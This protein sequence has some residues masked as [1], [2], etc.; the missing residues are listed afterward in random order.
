MTVLGLLVA[1]FITQ[2]Q[3]FLPTFSAQASFQSKTVQQDSISNQHLSALVVRIDSKSNLSSSNNKYQKILII[4]SNKIFRNGSY[5]SINKRRYPRKITYSPSLTNCSTNVPPVLKT[6]FGLIPKKEWDMPQTP[7]Y[8]AEQRLLAQYYRGRQLPVL[9]YGNTGNA[10]RVLQTLL[11]YNR[12]RVR[13]TGDFDVITEAAV[14]AFQSN[15]RLAADG[16]VGSRT[17][18]E[19]TR[20]A[21]IY[22]KRDP[23]EIPMFGNEPLLPWQR[24]FRGNLAE[25]TLSI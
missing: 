24:S 15:R 10:V 22:S 14:K 16:I 13:V 18:R 12:Y 19:L 11:M 3:P 8:D 23:M 21:T 7:L 2:G 9:R 20:Y 25:S 4:L 17:W 5:K 6:S 1:S